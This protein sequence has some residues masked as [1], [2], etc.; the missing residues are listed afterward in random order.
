MTL[1]APSALSRRTFIAGL[2]A[3]GGTL[4]LVLHAA[5]RAP[6]IRSQIRA[7]VFEGEALLLAGAAVGRST[8]GGATWT[9]LSAQPPGAVASLACH[10][11]RPGLILAASAAVGVS[12]SDDGG[13]HWREA[14][15]GLPAAQVDAVAIS[16]H[17]PDMLYASVRGD[18]LWRS[19]DG[20]GAW[21]FAMDR[22]F[23]EAA[24]RDVLALASVNNP[25]DMGGYWIF[26]GTARNVTKVPDCFC[27]WYSVGNSGLPRGPV[28][29]L[30]LAPSLPD[31]LFAGLPSGVWRSDDAGESWRLA[32][33][34]LSSPC[35]A[36]DPA[37][38]DHVVAAAESAVLASRDG[39][40]IWAARAA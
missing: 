16:A 38:P 24:E 29:S 20:G 12:R 18:G 27:R 26:A 2:A 5:P 17:D 14:S 30:A 21:E 3:A 31:V 34:A 25:T 37:D 6:G 8:D 40:L 36:V 11:E 7:L 33:D 35:V 10:P 23:E 15:S 4:P 1:R 32:M 39:G 9:D 13:A 22:P 28:T 19:G